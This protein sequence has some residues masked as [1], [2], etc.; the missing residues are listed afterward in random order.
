MIKTLKN[1]WNNDFG[2]LNFLSGIMISSS[3]NTLTGYCMSV[4]PSGFGL[5]SSLFTLASSAYLFALYQI[6]NSTK[7]EME[8]EI[9]NYDCRLSPR[10]LTIRKK[11]IW[12]KYVYKSLP[13]IRKR[14]I[15][16]IFTGSIGLIV[17][18]ILSYI[19]TS[20]GGTMLSDCW[21]SIWTSFLANRAN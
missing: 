7:R 13:K 16:A 21:K 17:L 15:G 6:L 2:W 1:Q 3:I 14:L 18:L 11:E 12:I 4:N 19:D 5:L 8:N 10:D 9:N 20:K